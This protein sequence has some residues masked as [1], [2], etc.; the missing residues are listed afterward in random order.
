MWP[1]CEKV[2]ANPLLFEWGS[3]SGPDEHLPQ[4]GKELHTT[5][6]IGLN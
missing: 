3:E 5:T 2:F 4:K 1:Q 6:L